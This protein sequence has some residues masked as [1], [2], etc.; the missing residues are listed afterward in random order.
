MEIL[1]TREQIERIVIDELSFL[2]SWER[3]VHE[4]DRDVVLLDALHLVRKQFEL[5]K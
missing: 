2:I 1:L 3:E 5:L 4:D